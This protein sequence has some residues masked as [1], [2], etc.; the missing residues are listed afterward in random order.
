MNGI[1]WPSPAANLQNIEAEIKEVLAATGVQVP[2]FMGM[3]QGLAIFQ[4]Y[5]YM[6]LLCLCVDMCV[7]F[8]Y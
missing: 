1:D 4:L 8:S 2:S 3:H 7:Y 5:C 6:F